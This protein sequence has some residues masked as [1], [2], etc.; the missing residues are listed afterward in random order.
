MT[1]RATGGFAEE[2]R[3]GRREEA[4]ETLVTI[5][6]HK[7]Y[8]LALTMLRN[9]QAAEDATQETFL[10]VWKALPGF[11]G[12][13]EISTWIYSIA[14]N[15]CLS[16][17]NRSSSKCEIGMEELPEQTAPPHDPDPFPTLMEALGQLDGRQ[18]EAVALFYLEDKS[19]EEMSQQ[20]GIP[21][22]SV[23]TYLHRARRVLAT[24]FQTRDAEV[25]ADG[26]GTGQ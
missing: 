20:M 1:E 16:M 21:I 10:R 3:S 6:Q 15:R 2:A 22:G 17:L 7:V 8:R 5:Y 18:R 26:K 4:F 12:D 19:Y 24:F 9:P 23:K 13:S 14:R 11:R 25:P